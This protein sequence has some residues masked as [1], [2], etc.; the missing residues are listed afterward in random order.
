MCPFSLDHNTSPSHARQDPGRQG[1][2]RGGPMARRGP[3][4]R[5][6]REA[7]PACGHTCRE[8]ARAPGRRVGGG[9]APGR[10]GGGAGA[11][12]VEGAAASTCGRGVRRF[13]KRLGGVRT[14][15]F[16]P[17]GT[18]A[19]DPRGPQAAL[20]GAGRSAVGGRPTSLPPWPAGSTRGAASSPCPL[21]VG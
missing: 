19:L 10:L 16:A 14:C 7:P 18:E 8:G 1:L 21:L 12:G 15:A 5:P 13:R 3:S 9:I 4:P 2:P 11:D 6:P 17:G 20:R